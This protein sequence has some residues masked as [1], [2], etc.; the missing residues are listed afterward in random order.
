MSVGVVHLTWRNGLDEAEAAEVMTL[1]VETEAADGVA[2]VGEHVILRLKAHRGVSEQIEPVQADVGGS[3]HFVVRDTG[4]SLV[5]YAHLDTVGE[6]DAASGGP[7]VAELAVHPNHRGRGA[8]TKLVEALLERA[9]LPLAAPAEQRTADGLR[10]WSH[11]EHPAALRLAGKYGF[12]RS[13]ELWRMGR[14]LAG[15]E[16]PEA[17]LPEGVSVRAFRPGQDEA[18][19][20]RVNHRAF[21]WHPEQGGM[22]AAELRGKQREDWFDSDGF[23]LAVSPSDELLGFHWTKIHPD[24]TGEV[25]VLGVDPNT[26]GSGLG[27][28][29][30]I[31]GIRYLQQV[32]CPRVMLYVEADNGPAVRVYQRLGFQRWD[33]DVQFG[34]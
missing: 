26:Q 24:R 20:V 2:P 1:L 33:V 10:I 25:Y 13:R 6:G 11:G 3:E 21:S 7:L 16:L 5:G 28:A 15:M 17:V 27:R 29:L 8:G 12:G 30:T 19:V 23:L 18:A 9:E 14:D 4:G 31:A 22:D 34:R 32:G